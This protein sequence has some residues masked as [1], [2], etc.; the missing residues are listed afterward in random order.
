MRK[1]I[2]I[3]GDTLIDKTY[4]VKTSRVSP[5]ASC[6]IGELDSRSPIITPGGAS[7]GAS[8]AQRKNIPY[9]FVTL[10]DDNNKNFLESKKISLTKLE[11]T[12]NSEKIRYIERDNNY[13]LIR[14]DNDNIIEKTIL[15]YKKLSD[16]I[17]RDKEKILVL[18][19][20]DYNKGFFNSDIFSKLIKE[21]NSLSIPIY[22]DSRKNGEFCKD[23]TFLKINHLEFLELS[24]L[25]KTSCEREIKDLLNLDRLI[26][27][28]GKDGAILI[29]RDN[30]ILDLIPKTLNGN[31][32]VTGCG[33]VFDINFC[34]AFFLKK[35]K[36]E[37]SLQFAID[38]ATKYAYTSI[39]TRLC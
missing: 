16:L 36:T 38:A 39:K 30:S 37:E 17:N 29:D 13:H 5:E 15:D 26:I 4:Y 33:D 23:A 35:Y 34:Y 27:T 3:L 6:L 21:A 7:L 32:D 20:L 22:I 9:H 25:F 1:K 19:C 24:C 11:D 10:V 12:E 14:I 2:Y 8:Y 18:V 28:K 31:P